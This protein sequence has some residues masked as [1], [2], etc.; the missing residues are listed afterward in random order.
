[1]CCPEV[2]APCN[3]L[4]RDKKPSSSPRRLAAGSWPVATHHSA[5]LWHNAFC[6]QNRHT[7]SS[8][9]AQK[10]VFT[11]CKIRFSRTKNA[12]SSENSPLRGATIL[13]RS[14]HA[15]CARIS[16]TSYLLTALAS[17]ALRDM[18]RVAVTQLILGL[19]APFQRHPVA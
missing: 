13:L 19:F 4:P 17:L 1:M 9:A 16:T 14:F 5:F 10:F 18:L 12:K 6:C 2:P 8:R 15:R 11:H 7:N 3:R